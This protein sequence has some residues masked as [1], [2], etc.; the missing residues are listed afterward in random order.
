MSDH[1]DAS[2]GQPASA[3]P[4]R[5]AGPAGPAGQGPDG[6][7]GHGVN[8]R[9]AIKMS[10]DEIQAF[11]E[12]RRPM[13]MCTVNHD[14]TIH[15]VAMWYGLVDGMIAIETK[16]K[17]QKAR[18]LARDPRATLLFEDGDY[19]EELRGVELVCRAEVIDDPE[20]MWALGVNLYERYYGTYRDELRPFVE[21]MLNKRIVAVF[22]VDRTVSWDHRKLG[23]PSTRPPA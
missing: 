16:A 14:G 1:P 3:G 19:Y 20:R 7:M 12:E 6:A 15:A 8:Q 10:P 18:N 9:S 13:T 17:S 4:A 23:L 22:H 21:A 11:I 5:P 2:Q